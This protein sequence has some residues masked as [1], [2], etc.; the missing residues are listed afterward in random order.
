MMEVI[1]DPVR[2][3]G[4]NQSPETLLQFIDRNNNKLVAA[5]AMDTGHGR[6]SVKVPGL[7]ETMEDIVNLPVKVN[8]DA[9]VRF[10]DVATLHRTFKDSDGYVRSNRTGT[11]ILRY[12]VSCDDDLQ[13]ARLFKIRYK[14]DGANARVEAKLIR[15]PLWDG[16]P[17]T[18]A[19]FDSDSRPSFAGFVR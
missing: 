10:R 11:V 14:D 2:L 7:F 13:R 3:Q 15:T 8:G 19:E 6:F 17:Q 9:V 4:F 16:E 5:G 1:I 18:L 12:P